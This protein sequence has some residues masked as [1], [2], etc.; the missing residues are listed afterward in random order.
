MALWRSV[1]LL[2]RAAVEQWVRTSFPTLADVYLLDMEDAVP[3]KEKADTR[4]YYAPFVH[5]WVYKI[6][7]YVR[8]NGWENEKELLDDVNVLLTKNITGVFLPKVEDQHEILKMD[9]LLAKHEQKMALG[10]NKFKIVSMIESPLASFRSLDIAQCCPGRHVALAVGSYDFSAECGVAENSAALDNAIQTTIFAAK[11]TG[12]S[13]ISS[14]GICDMSDMIE[15]EKRCQEVKACGL[16][17]IIT[18]SNAQT[19]VA[20]KVFSQSRKEVEMAKIIKKMYEE[21]SSKL[22]QASP[23][24]S[25]IL[26]AQPFLKIAQKTLEKHG[27]ETE[28]DNKKQDMLPS[29]ATN[30]NSMGQKYQKAIPIKTK[31]AE[32]QGKSAGYTFKTPFE[33]T[34][35]PSIKTAWDMSFFNQSLMCSSQEW[36]K[37]CGMSDVHVPFTLLPFLAI[38][39]AVSMYVALCLCLLIGYMAHS[40]CLSCFLN[41][42]SFAPKQNGRE[43]FIPHH[44]LILQC[45][46]HSDLHIHLA[47]PP[48]RP[49]PRHTPQFHHDP[50][51]F[52]EV[53]GFKK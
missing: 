22:F 32:I 15:L 17:G 43:R 41:Y 13:V 6:P 23:Q 48:G 53:G 18:L 42:F 28:Y 27:M 35:F 21:E 36:A 34:L 8:V 47:P 26:M 2:N 37:R 46:V 12:L 20:Q 31:N 4:K 33:I 14:S 11:S 16:D 9:Q 44:T 39:M 7:L 52:D 29:D 50:F 5:N 49:A 40:L 25:Q 24:E 10:E 3:A 1:H 19:T 45:N 51:M 38:S 30:V